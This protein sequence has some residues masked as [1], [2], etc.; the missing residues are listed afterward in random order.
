MPAFTPSSTAQ[1]FVLYDE[2]AAGLDPV[3]SQKIYDLLAA[4]HA[5]T[6]A[7]VLAVSSDVAALA[8][9]VDEI[10][11]VY[12]GRVQ[13]LGPAGTIADAPDPLVRQYFQEGIGPQA[14]NYRIISR[15]VVAGYRTMRERSTSPASPSMR[16]TD[17]AALGG[18]LK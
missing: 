6:G 10:A 15:K 14:G 2:P 11:F 3:T 18:T 7:S 5:R 9:F 1:P 16:T 8:R 17:S 4:D 13:Y 12:R